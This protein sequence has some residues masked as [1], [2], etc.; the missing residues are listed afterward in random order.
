MRKPYRLADHQCR[1]VKIFP[2]YSSEIPDALYYNPDTVPDLT[3]FPYPLPSPAAAYTCEAY[4]EDGARWL[5]AEGGLARVD[6]N[7]ERAQDRI[8][9]FCS[10]RWLADDA[11]RALYAEGNTLWAL[12]KTG[13]SRIEMR[14]ISC[15]HKA[16]LLTQESLRYVD[17]RGLV[18]NQSLR[19]LRDLDS[20]RGDTLSDNDGGF[21]AAF[22]VGEILHYAYL[23]R[24]LGEAAART[25]DVKACALR[26]AEACL[27]TLNVS[28]RGDGFPARTY[29]VA[30]ERIPDDGLFYQ[31]R[32]D[33]FA[34]CLDTR[35]ARE[36]GIVGKKVRCD[37]PVPDRLARQYR[38]P[39][40]NDDDVIY[41][42][43]TSSDEVTLHFLNMLFMFDH[44]CVGDDELRTLVVSSCENLLNHIIDNGLVVREMDGKPT[45]WGRWDPEYFNT[46][47]GW[48]DA[49][50][51]SAQILMYLNVAEHIC[52]KREKWTLCRRQLIAKYHYDE[53]PE[54]HLD[55]FTHASYAMGADCDEEMMYGDNMLAVVAFYGLITL[56]T[57]PEQKA[58]YI[59]G[60]RSWDHSLLREHNPGYR[61][62]CMMADPDYPD[63]MDGI[64]EWFYRMPVSRLASQ[65]RLDRAD[66]PVRIGLGGY[67]STDWLLE[68]DET[69]ITKY[70]RNPYRYEPMSEG[71]NYLE[72]CYPYTFA[73][74]FGK[75]FGIIE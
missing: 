58:K 48:A 53:L 61:F 35:D 2:L 49:C 30:S 47:V 24:K 36:R 66:V 75:Y 74:W 29:A 43:D 14:E 15:E 42:G 60:L 13:V 18:S 71:G 8:M 73:Y 31:K 25:Q 9:Y 27:L 19:E 26:A 37:A 12:C 17:R 65:V 63:D 41:K 5:G 32:A 51:N 70:D 67:T 22:A 55:R 45:T 62:L 23:K 10:D 40:Y 54:K 56:E 69:A 33:G 20:V 39:G 68:P 59:R 50:L 57:D 38:D 16:E 34:V 46:E 11:V 64:A 4:T 44:L 28:G 6:L 7:A 52:G 3:D 72:S 21:T 1:F